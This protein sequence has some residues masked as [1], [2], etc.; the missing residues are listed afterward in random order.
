[1]GQGNNKIQSPPSLEVVY[2]NVERLFGDL[3]E[4]SKVEQ[5]NDPIITISRN[6]SELGSF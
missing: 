6:M 2:Q 1:M 3:S 5:V 4:G